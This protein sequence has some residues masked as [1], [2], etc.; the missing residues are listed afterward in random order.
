MKLNASFSTTSSSSSALSIFSTRSRRSE[1]MVEA[2][3]KNGEDPFPV[4]VKE[5]NV[6]WIDLATA[7]MLLKIE[8]EE[9]DAAAQT[10]Q[11]SIAE[12]N[13]S[14]SSSSNNNTR[15]TAN[16]IQH[17]NVNNIAQARKQG[18]T[19]ITSSSAVLTSPTV[20]TVDQS[21]D[22]GLKVTFS[23]EVVLFLSPDGLSFLG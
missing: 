20:S 10:T 19:F 2:A 3:V 18:Q 7:K 23:D 13:S 1:A 11:T 15:N 5:P 16:T 8:R 6:R 14:S 4:V 22:G 17:E 9:N 12:P 21:D